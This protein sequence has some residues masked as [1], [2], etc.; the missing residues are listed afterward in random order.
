MSKPI[1]F[2]PEAERD[3]YNILQW[4]IEIN[5]FVTDKFTDEIDESLHIISE[6]PQIGA[7]YKFKIR[8][9]VLIKFPYVIFYIEED[10]EIIILAIFHGHSNPEVI[11]RVLE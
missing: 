5:K 4:Y 9:Y 1:R 2:K 3:F 11:R 7:N 6:N 10:I 8:K